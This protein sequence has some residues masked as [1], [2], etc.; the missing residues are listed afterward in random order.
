MATRRKSILLL[1][2][3]VI[4]ILLVALTVAHFIRPARS[5][6]IKLDGSPG[7]SIAATFG[8]DGRTTNETLTTPSTRSFRA[9]RFSYSLAR[10]QQPGKPDLSLEV[11]V[12]DIPQGDWRTDS[13]GQGIDGWI[14][15]PS[16][17][18]LV[19]GEYAM[20]ATK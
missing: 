11:F 4:A 15:T 20:G 8:V 7:Q 12:D 2:S 18:H 9:S 17:F 19:G 6:T 14:R 10:E 3:V 16:L 13:P 5:I 1:S